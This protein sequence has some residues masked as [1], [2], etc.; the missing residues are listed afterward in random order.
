M[1]VCYFVNDFVVY[2]SAA[3]QYR[4]VSFTKNMQFYIFTCVLNTCNSAKHLN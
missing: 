2:V 4:F 1:H 3:T